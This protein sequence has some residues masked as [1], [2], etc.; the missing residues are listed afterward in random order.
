MTSAC[1]PLEPPKTVSDFCL[2]DRRISIEPAPAAGTTDPGNQWDTEQTVAEALEHNAV[3][4]R[5]C[6]A[7]RK[8]A[9][10]RR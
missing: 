5:L 7:P 3:H 1:D 6:P 10:N 4:D 9:M 8:T 2:N